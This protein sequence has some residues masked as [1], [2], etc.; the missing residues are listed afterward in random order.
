MGVTGRSPGLPGGEQGSTHSTAC[1]PGGA[2]VR[3]RP[4]APARLGGS[5]PPAPR[6]TRQPDCGFLPTVQ[7]DLLQPRHELSS[8]RPHPPA[9]PLW[10]YVAGVV[11]GTL[12]GSAVSGPKAPRSLTEPSRK[13][14]ARARGGVPGHWGPSGS[15]G[16]RCWPRLEQAFTQGR[17]G[18][19]LGQ[20]ALSWAMG[21]NRFQPPA[22]GKAR[23]LRG[24]P[25]TQSSRP[26]LPAEGHV[27]SR[28]VTAICP[29]SA[30]CCSV[31]PEPRGCRGAKGT[32][33]GGRCL[34]PGSSRS[35]WTILLTR[36]GA[37]A[38]A[39]CAA[40]RAPVHVLLTRSP[41]G[42]TRRRHRVPDSE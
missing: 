11:T 1:V 19:A 38:T 28:P 23:G 9:V 26:R 4:A 13:A 12:S 27:P 37:R 30:L 18:E 2:R 36:G 31:T 8:D 39:A 42:P 7:V 22:R 5:P 3:A 16:D 6:S 33:G 29:Q 25:E 21:A 34:A 40:C 17:R 14:A 20:V 41:G 10:L 32:G 15:G 24:S 35:A